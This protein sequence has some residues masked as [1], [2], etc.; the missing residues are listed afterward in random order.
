MGVRGEGGGESFIRFLFTAITIMKFT[1]QFYASVHAIKVFQFPDT[2]LEVVII[3]I[4]SPNTG[5][6]M[7]VLRR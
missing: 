2:G 7:F 3:Y 6:V 1:H 4:F 5:S